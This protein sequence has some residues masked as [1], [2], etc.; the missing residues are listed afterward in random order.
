MSLR[1]GRWVQII[2]ACGLGLVQCENLNK[3]RA[4]GPCVAVDAVDTDE[5]AMSD[6]AIA[7]TTCAGKGRSQRRPFNDNDKAIKVASL[8]NA[9]F[10]P[11]AMRAYGNHDGW[12][13]LLHI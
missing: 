6:A 10:L 13:C 9:S 4:T 5:G 1:C 7:A 11:C 3:G 8:Y 12:Q 2:L